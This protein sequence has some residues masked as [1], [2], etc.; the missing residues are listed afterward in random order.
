MAEELLLLL[1]DELSA[2]LVASSPLSCA[3]A[4]AI[5][6]ELA[7]TGRIDVNDD[8]GGGLV[9]SNGSPTGDEVLDE[10]L[11]V[12]AACKDCD[13]SEAMAVLGE[14]LRTRLVA[15]LA[16]RGARRRADTAVLGLLRR[17]TWPVQDLTHE[18]ELCAAMVDTLVRGTE[19]QPLTGALIGL[20]SAVGKVPVAIS[21]RHFGLTAA[22]LNR[23]ADAVTPDRWAAASAETAIATILHAVSAAAAASGT[24]ATSAG[25]S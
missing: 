4:G 3:L 17:A 6:V 10:G 19:P 1:K 25:E 2:A 5:M 23:R 16:E 15:R 11:A 12:V 18:Q 7:L 8:P 13:P 22:E 14:R 21:A 24:R 20:L 9:V